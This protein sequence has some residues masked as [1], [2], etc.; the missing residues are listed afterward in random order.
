MGR[1]LLLFLVQT[2]VPIEIL[3]SVQAAGRIERVKGGIRCMREPM[4]GILGLEECRRISPVDAL[5]ER[6]QINAW[7]ESSHRAIASQAQG[8]DN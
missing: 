4:K 2:L 3:H 1:G 7:F 5:W 8:T 6:R